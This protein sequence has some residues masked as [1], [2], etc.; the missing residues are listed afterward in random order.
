[1]KAHERTSKIQIGCCDGE[2]MNGSFIE[3]CRIQICNDRRHLAVFLL[4]ILTDAALSDCEKLGIERTSSAQRDLG[5][6][7]I[8]YHSLFD[9]LFCKR[10]K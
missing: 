9:I 1:M 6:E 5:T 8:G 4:L 7:T 3:I 2:I 10:N